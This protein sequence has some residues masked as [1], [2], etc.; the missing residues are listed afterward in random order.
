MWETTEKVF[1]FRVRGGWI[2]VP[3]PSGLLGGSGSSA[4][5]RKRYKRPNRD[6]NWDSLLGKPT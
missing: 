6:P 1:G 4:G 5:T 3:G 2:L